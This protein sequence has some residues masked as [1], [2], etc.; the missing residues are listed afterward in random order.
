MFKTAAKKLAHS[1]T[2]PGLAGNPRLQ[3]LQELI[4]AEKL[5][6]QSY[7]HGP[8]KS[9]PDS[10]PPLP[11]FSLQRLSAGFDRSSE[12]LKEWAIGEGDDL[13]V[14]STINLSFSH[15]SGHLRIR[16]PHARRC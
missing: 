14:R 6:Y 16:F 4:A 12:A 13:E 10:D 5:V 2:I 1:A 3:P 15:E 8:R 9:R 11:V 7:V